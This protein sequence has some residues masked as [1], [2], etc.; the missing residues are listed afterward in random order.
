MNPTQRRVM[1]TGGP[2]FAGPGIIARLIETGYSVTSVDLQLW[3]EAPCHHMQADLRDLGQAIELF[4]GYDTVVHLA[5]VRMGGVQPQTR[6]FE[7]NFNTTY[8]VFRAASLMGVRRVVWASTCGLM[9]SPFGDIKDVWW[10]AGAVSGEGRAVP[11]RLPFVETDPPHP[12]TSY[13]LSKVT[14]EQLAR[15]PQI[16]GKTSFVALRY[17][18][19]SYE[20]MYAAFEKAWTEPKLRSYHLW[21]YVDMRD[22]AEVCALAIEAKVEGAQ[23]YFITA[24]DTFMPQPSRELIKS[25]FPETVISN[26]LAEHG[27][28][29]SIEKAR[30]ELGYQPRYSWREVMKK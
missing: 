25:F 6:T 20:P 29:F 14:L 28:L 5:A 17:G 26:D 24:A 8:N 16:W 21:N 11:K 9:G 2:G 12:M 4:G 10:A 15:N 23:E 30:R 13:H 19:M 27:T 22:A 7:T 1:V 3:P 18:N